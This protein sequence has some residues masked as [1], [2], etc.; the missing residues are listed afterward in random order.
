MKP[1]SRVRSTAPGEDGYILAGVIILIAILMISLAAAVPKVR[2][3]LQ[4]DQEL[5]TM[6]RGRQYIRA[7]QLYYRRFHRFPPSVDALLSTNNLRFLRQR[8]PDPITGKDDWTP[9]LLGQNKAPLSMAYFG[10]PLN[11]GSAVAAANST[12]PANRILGA[13]PVLASF[14]G[15]AASAGN[16]NTGASPSAGAAGAV[17]GGAGIMGVSPVT[18]KQS[19]LVYKTKD[20]YDEWEFVYDPAADHPGM[21]L[22]PPQPPA[23]PVN[24]GAPGFGPTAPLGNQ[25]PGASSSQN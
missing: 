24:T 7:I 21:L 19:L 8:Y 16:A 10:Q 18:S 11:M 14:G 13:S 12:S 9:V 4:R 2:E 3:Q 5:E 20:H 17:Y 15:D 25:G 23:P 6:H 22:A 1:L